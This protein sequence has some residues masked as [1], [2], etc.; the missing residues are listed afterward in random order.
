MTLRPDDLFFNR[1]SYRAAHTQFAA[2]FMLPLPWYFAYC[3]Y[4]Q[5]GRVIAV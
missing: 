3:G 4:G 2:S 5:S 1:D